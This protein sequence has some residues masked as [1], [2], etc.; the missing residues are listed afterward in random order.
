MFKIYKKHNKT[1][2]T[3]IIE[4]YGNDKSTYAQINLI[5]GGS[6][7]KL[8]FNNISVIK[9]IKQLDYKTT[10]ASSILFPFASRIK[11]GEYTFLN[12]LYR[13]PLNDEHKQNAL[14]GLVYNKPFKMIK[15]DTNKNSAQV[16]LE[17]N[18]EEFIAGFPF[19]FSLQLSYTLTNNDLKLE[20]TV[21]NTGNESFPFSIGWHPY[22]WSSNLYLSEL[23]FNSSK[24]ITFAHPFIQTREVSCKN[25][26]TIIIGDRKFDDCFVLNDAKVQFKTPNY[27]ISIN[28]SSA[29]N[30][31]LVYTINEIGVIALEPLTAPPN[32]FI[33]KKSLKIIEPNTQCSTIWNIELISKTI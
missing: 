24:K 22:F 14:H 17:Y 15:Y 21:L 5:N 26:G 10:F 23:S 3:A 9:N 31:L 4:I 12:K 8:K 30:Y 28:S 18:H 19:K 2:N 6:L 11:D 33:N 27:T 20:A 25:N 13:L 32:C 7:Q 16:A 1:K 29:D